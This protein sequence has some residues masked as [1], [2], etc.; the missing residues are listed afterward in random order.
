MMLPEISEP[1]E[2]NILDAEGQSAA[3]LIEFIP[4]YHRTDF[5]EALRS[6]LTTLTSLVPSMSSQVVSILTRRCCDALLPVR[7]IPSQFRGMSNKGL[8][9][10]P[11][12]FVSNVLRELKVFFAVGVSDGPGLP[13]KEDLL[14]PYA[15][16]VFD[17][18]SQRSILFSYRL[19]FA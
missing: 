12:Y 11:S 16:E 17:N 1:V 13:L 4:S 5:I 9:N 15:T 18:V 7:S 3:L 8:P 10:E 14:V 2:G 19:S 6:A